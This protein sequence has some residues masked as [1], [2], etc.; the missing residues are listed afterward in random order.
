MISRSINRALVDFAINYSPPL[1]TEKPDDP[2][3]RQA[4]AKSRAAGSESILVTPYEVPFL[5]TVQ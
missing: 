2:I 3:A 1:Y 4:T 5:H